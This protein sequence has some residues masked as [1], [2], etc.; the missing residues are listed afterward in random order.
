LT[1]D[2]GILADGSVDVEWWVALYREQG[3]SV[4]PLTPGTKRPE[5]EWRGYVSAGKHST[6][7]ERRMWLRSGRGVAAVCGAPSG[8]VWALD[9]ERREDFEQLMGPSTLNST[10][11][12]ETPHGGIHV[13]FRSKGR[14]PRRRI[15]AA[16]PRHPLDILGEGGIAVLPPTA[17]DHRRC[18]G[19]GLEGVDAGLGPGVTRYRVI[20]T[21]TDIAT[22]KEGAP[23]HTLVD[24]FIRAGWIRE[25]DRVSALIRLGAGIET[26]GGAGGGGR[27]EGGEGG[28]TPR[29]DPALTRR[30][31]RDAG[32]LPPRV[33]WGENVPRLF[34]GVGEGRRNNTAF[35]LTRF[36]L[37]YAGFDEHTAWRI[38]E[39]WNTGRNTPPLPAEEL[40]RVFDSAKKY[41]Y[42]EREKAGTEDDEGVGDNGGAGRSVDE[43]RRRVTRKFRLNP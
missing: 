40:R 21:T 5:E 38:L 26:S 9:F 16:G 22:L 33:V 36:L 15:Q 11:V 19:C 43:K 1:T 2:P 12:V 14:V 20:S 6:D 28:V 25:E 27:G 17:V 30:L 31:K 3:L 41:T 29:V 39:E 32:A 13:Y 35:F 23:E 7:D 24:A 42:I 18:G 4:I 34:G 37:Y 8:G 10:L